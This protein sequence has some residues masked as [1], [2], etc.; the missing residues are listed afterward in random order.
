MRR[1]GGPNFAVLEDTG[2]H[3][4]A[5]AHRQRNA[6]KTVARDAVLGFPQ[7]RVAVGPVGCQMQIGFLEASGDD[8]DEVAVSEQL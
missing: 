1:E 3:A 7:R 6:R 2:Q 5:R 8:A 4:E